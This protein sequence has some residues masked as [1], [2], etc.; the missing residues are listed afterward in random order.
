MNDTERNMLEKAIEVAVVAHA[1]H[2]DKNGEA[3]ILHPAR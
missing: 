3:Y 2:V 1:G